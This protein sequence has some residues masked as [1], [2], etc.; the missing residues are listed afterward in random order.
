MRVFMN[1]LSILLLLLI[2][3]CN[4]NPATPKP[5]VQQPYFKPG[6]YGG[7]AM[8]GTEWITSAYP[9]PDGKKIALVRYCTPGR[10]GSDPRYQLWIVNNDGSDPELIAT[11]SGGASWSP[12]GSKIAFI[13]TIL[14]DTYIFIVDLNTMKV[15][16]LDG[17]SSQYFDKTTVS[18]PHWFKDGNRL[19]LS[20]WGKAYQQSFERGF[21]IMNLETDSIQG[22]LVPIAQVGQLG[23]NENYITGMKYTTQGDPQSG[24]YIR[25]D[26]ATK[27]WH[28]ITHV[29]DEKVKDNYIFLSPSPTSPTIVY[30]KLVDN[31]PQ[32]FVT[33][34][35]GTNAHQLTRLGGIWPN[36]SP[37][38]S[39]FTFSR[40]I[41]KGIGAHY[42]MMKCSA[43][44]WK[45]TPLWPNLSDSVPK[46]PPVSTQ[47][48]I[49]LYSIIQHN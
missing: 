6:E 37:D 4:N 46:F 31:A 11:G 14:P 36:W 5:P 32:I 25:Y 26:F 21:Y 42:V 43:P 16:Q 15:T 12:D 40:D 27:Q 41:H 3:S 13:Y 33:D 17:K 19:L 8:S 7:N 47:H 2:G 10:L 20:V 1:I 48:P 38:G 29:T 9:S 23:D 35:S 44:D 39:F 22:P 24:N 45:I 30:S 34:S 28:W 18:N 49:D